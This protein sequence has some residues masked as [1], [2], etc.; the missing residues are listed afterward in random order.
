MSEPAK[1]PWYRPPGTTNIVS[2]EQ[3]PQRGRPA[4]IAI[5]ASEKDADLIVHCVNHHE[6]LVKMLHV[7]AIVLENAQDITGAISFG[8][9]AHKARA[10]L[11]KVK[12]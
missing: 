8:D 12:V 10:L 11:E 5:A 9:V 6:E 4:P 2:L 3:A 1:R 7:A